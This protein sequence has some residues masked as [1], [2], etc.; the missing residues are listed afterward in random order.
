MPSLCSDESELQGVFHT[1][2][3]VF[4]TQ[5]GKPDPVVDALRAVVMSDIQHDSVF[6]TV[7][8]KSGCDVAYQEFSAPPPTP[9]GCGV[10]FCDGRDAL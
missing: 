2:G 10:H 8:K 6:S 1:V 7:K 5:S 9:H 4:S 3:L